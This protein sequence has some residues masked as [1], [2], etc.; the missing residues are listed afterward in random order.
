[1]TVAQTTCDAPA[2]TLDVLIIGGGIMGL[3]LLM[4]LQRLGYAVLLLERQELGGEQ[5]CH[6]HVYIHL[7]YLYNTIALATHLKEVQRQWQAWF[8]DHPPQGKTM[9]SH[10]GFRN[11]AD[12]TR[13]TDLW[14]HPDLGLQSVALARTAW[15][16]ALQGSTMQV[17][18]Q[19]PEFGV[20]GTWLMQ[21][22]SQERADYISRIEAVT[23]IRVNRQTALVEAVEV[24]LPQDPHLTLHPKAVVLAAGKGNQALLEQATWGHAAWHTRART[25][26]QIRKGHMLVVRGAHDALPPLTG[27]FPSYRGL[28][29]VSR[30]LGEETV[31]LISDNRSEGIKDDTDWQAYNAPWWLPEVWMA[32]QE[33]APRVF[34]HP[35]RFQW[36]LYEAPKA[37]GKHGGVIPSEERIV[38]CGPRNLWAVWPTKLTLAPRASQ[39]LVRHLQRFIPQPTR[40]AAL[41]PAWRAARVPALVA[42]ELWTRTPLIA[43][44]A[45]R[46][47]HGL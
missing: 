13:K 11:P 26:Q 47:M 25:A 16:A 24:A 38:Q 12:A 30:D 10:F 34:T 17:V 2:I 7:G 32:L 20:D 18:L 35:E 36:G 43:W 14:A 39:T 3:W 46:Q 15:P 9:R 42:P 8:A 45:F 6:S 5:T 23:D 4:E 29:I 37:E 31:W 1:M 22:L 33:V 41:P 28:F 19:T 40:W 27:V 21:A 44:H